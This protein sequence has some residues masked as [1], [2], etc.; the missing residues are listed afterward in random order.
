MAINPNDFTDKVNTTL[1]DA[2]NLAIEAGH[3]QIEPIHL[4]VVLFDDAEGMARRVVQKA[5]SDI[6]SVRQGLR[7]IMTK[8]PAQSPQPLDAN[9]SSATLRLLQNAQKIQRKNDEGHTA[10]D[11]LLMALMQEKEILQALAGFGLSKGH[12]EETLKRVKGTNKADSKTA[13]SNYEALA[14]YGIDLVQLAGDGKMDPVLGRD[15]EIRRV[16]QIL[17]RRTKSNPCLVG[18]PGK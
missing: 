5:G 18:P 7:A 2:K 15:E 13:E 8:L 4:A 10:I 16:I 12:F 6:D 14:K 1:Y 11:H 17:S 9:A 3:A